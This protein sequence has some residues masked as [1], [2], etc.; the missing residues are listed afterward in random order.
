MG[1]YLIGV[2][3]GFKSIKAL[4]RYAKDHLKS[5]FPG[6]PEYAAFV[7][8]VNRLHEAFRQLIANLQVAQVTKDDDDVYL[9]DSFPIMLAQHNHAY[10]AKIAPEVSGRGY[11]CP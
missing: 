1:V 5:W 6:L 9:M 10:T 8:R 4:H 7:H 11:C 3:R 2:L